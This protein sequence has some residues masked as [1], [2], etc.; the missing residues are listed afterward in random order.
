ME[1]PIYAAVSRQMALRSRMDTVADNMANMN[2]TGFKQS[3][4][5]F[6]EFLKKPQG[7]G[8][9]LSMV[10][11]FGQRQDFR[12]GVLQQT[13]NQLDIALEG[14]GFFAVQTA[15]GQRYTRDGHLHLDQTGRL[16]TA[17]GNAVLGAGGAQ[18]TIPVNARDIQI[19]SNGSIVTEQGPAGRIDVV[20]FDDAQDL[21]PEGRN[22]LA[23][24]NGAQPQPAESAGI[25]Q[26]ALEASNVEPVLAMTEMIEVLRQYQSIQSMIKSEYER[27]TNAIDKLGRVS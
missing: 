25:R 9:G 3:R 12:G 16:V 15:G 19:S 27:Q 20:T 4:V 2:T 21:V 6:T 26:N 23:A 22:L 5:Q 7:G 1:N 13:G 11:D 14:D 8:A 18:I 17:D 24:A 10:Q